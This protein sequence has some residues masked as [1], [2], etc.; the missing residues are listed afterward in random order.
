[1]SVFKGLFAYEIV[2]L[3]TGALLFLVLLFLLV[4]SVVRRQKITAYPFFFLISIAMMGF[5]GIQKL[6]VDRNGVEIDRLT[7]ELQQRPNDRK[8][9]LELTQKLNEINN[10]EPVLAPKMLLTVAK[11]QAVIGQKG[12]AL[13]NLD[14]ILRLAP[15]SSDTHSARI[16]KEELAK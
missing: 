11:A 9:H 2:L 14:K 7:K 3:V 8:V 13:K 10:R 12:Q 4:F 16:L 5:P 6:R 15:N 1:M